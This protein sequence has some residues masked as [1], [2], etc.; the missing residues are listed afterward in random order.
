MIGVMRR[1]VAVVAIGMLALPI[2]GADAAGPLY[3]NGPMPQFTPEIGKEGSGFAPAPVP[4]QGAAL[5][6]APPP[7]PGEPAIS[8]A[9]SPSAPQVRTGDG[10]TPGSS[11]N[12]ELQ[13][14]NRSATGAGLA[15][16]LQITVPM[17][18]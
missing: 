4:K 6:K 16:R 15:P 10:Y 14:R 5:P 3:L 13:R 12:D 7:R 1:M 2:H 18:N 8:G 11:F 17:E 9:V